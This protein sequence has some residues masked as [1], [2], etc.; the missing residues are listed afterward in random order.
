[1][2]PRTQREALT[3]VAAAMGAPAAKVSGI[4]WPVLRAVGVA[5][6]MM[7]EVVAIRHQWDQEYVSDAHATTAA[8]GL[9]ATP[10]DDV[11]RATVAAVREPA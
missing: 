10:W 5:V 1:T 3:D 4:P 6:P 2:A 7:R 8:F 11:V 9:Q